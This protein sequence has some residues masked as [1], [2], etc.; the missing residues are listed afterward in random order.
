MV[1]DHFV[2]SDLL[3]DLD[4]LIATALTSISMNGIRIRSQAS[5]SFATMQMEIRSGQQSWPHSPHLPFL[6]SSRRGAH[7]VGN[8]STAG[9]TSSAVST[10]DNRAIKFLP[11]R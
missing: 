9:G 3:V 1:K 8:S 10:V 2:A 7:A 6:F 11:A 5:Q 4:E